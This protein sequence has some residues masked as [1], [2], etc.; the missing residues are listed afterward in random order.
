MSQPMTKLAQ[1]KAAAALGDWQKAIA[2]AA[3]FPDLGEHR[4]A[5]LE[6]HTA[7]TNPRWMACIK[8]DAEAAKQSGIAALCLRYSLEHLIG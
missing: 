1:L 7:Y 4:G 6:A 3:K 8:K 2:I 5:I